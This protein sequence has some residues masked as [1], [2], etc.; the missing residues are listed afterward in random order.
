MD[1]KKPNY[2]ARLLIICVTCLALLLMLITILQYAVIP[3][4]LDSVVPPDKVNEP[5]NEVK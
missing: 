1:S 4:D 3:H 5:E 2:I